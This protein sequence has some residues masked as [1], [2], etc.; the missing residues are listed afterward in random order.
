MFLTS[1][2]INYTLSSEGQAWHVSS[3]VEIPVTDK[4]TVPDM[5]PRD[6]D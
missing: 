4:L 1:L 5:V 3:E 2:S 6:L